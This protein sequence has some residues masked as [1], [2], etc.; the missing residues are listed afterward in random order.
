MTIA[1][2]P[3]ARR[4]PGGNAA[5]LRT[6]FRAWRQ[7]RPFW[8]SAISIF[9]GLWIY[10]ASMAPLNVVVMQGLPGLLTMGIFLVT[11]VMAGVTLFQPHLR[12]ITGLIIVILGPLSIMATNLGGF[13]FGM[14]CLVVGGALILSWVPAEEQL[15][16][17]YIAGD[18]AAPTRTD[19]RP[20]A[21]HAPAGA[22]ARADAG[23]ATA[24]HRSTAPTSS[25]DVV[26]PIPASSLSAPAAPAAGTRGT[27]GTAGLVGRPAAKKT[28]AK[29]TAPGKKRPAPAKRSGLQGVFDTMFG[30]G[31][32]PADGRTASGPAG[33]RTPPAGKRTP[34]PGKRAAGPGQRPAGTAKKKPPPAKK[35]PPV[36]S[37]GD[38]GSTSGLTPIE[39][40][41]SD[42]PTAS[43]RTWIVIPV[44][45]IALAAPGVFAG[46]A[47]ATARAEGPF[48]WLF[49]PATPTPSAPAATPAPSPTP[50]PGFSIPS[51]PDLLNPTPTPAPSA[52]AAGT[53][54]PTLPTGDCSDAEDMKGTTSGGQAAIDAAAAMQACLS[55]AALPDD[56]EDIL[57]PK[58]P[59]DPATLPTASRNPLTLKA[60]RMEMQ[61]FSY[62][63]LGTINTSDGPT[64]VMHFS[65]SSIKVEGMDQTYGF[66]KN[67]VRIQDTSGG[68][69]T[70][71]GNVELYVTS[72]KSNIFGLIPFEFSATGL[73]P[74][75]VLPYMF[76]TDA[77]S[78]A[79]FT[80]CD[81]ILIPKIKA[82]ATAD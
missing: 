18:S 10:L 76:F 50:S 39:R 14:V 8:G 27:S 2:T 32:K 48:D 71:K 41:P 45:L 37:N 13:V 16:L 43:A 63:G 20:V 21:D 51:L 19:G 24:A 77:T 78:A 5:P 25:Y 81:Q 80:E 59:T 68:N 55:T 23:P 42:P 6:R 52:P 70:L 74:P 17:E 12:S 15:D 33:K 30:T 75:L 38:T 46:A 31:R 40:P 3:G 69:A 9:G 44:V 54:A 11:V 29:K 82:T 66:G 79:V 34:P 28:A 65:A 36:R 67:T 64:K 60:T 47:S 1:A 62:K 61:D 56:I 35:R 7:T 26:D 4:G 57:Q 73:Q 53:P 49:P 58:D 72:F 22:D